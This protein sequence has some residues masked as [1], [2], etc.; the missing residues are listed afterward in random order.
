[1]KDTRGSRWAANS[2]CLLPGDGGGGRSRY[3]YHNET[4]QDVRHYN[5]RWI[6]YYVNSTTSVLSYIPRSTEELHTLPVRHVHQLCSIAVQQSPPG[7]KEN[8]ETDV[9]VI[10]VLPDCMYARMEPSIWLQGYYNKE[11]S[12]RA[13]PVERPPKKGGVMCPTTY[14]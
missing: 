5:K 12:Y 7:K 1:M 6:H 9:D 11:Q 2:V 14:V 3:E 10:L 8:T 13:L 4:R